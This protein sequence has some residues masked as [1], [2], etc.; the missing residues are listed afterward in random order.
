MD[1]GSPCSAPLTP[2][3]GVVVNTMVVLLLFASLCDVVPSVHSGV[4][5]CPR[6]RLVAFESAS[7][8]RDH[9]RENWP[10][11]TI[12]MSSGYL[13]DIGEDRLIHSAVP[14]GCPEPQ[15]DLRRRSL[16]TIFTAPWRRSRIRSAGCGLLTLSA[17]EEVVTTLAQSAGASSAEEP[18]MLSSS[19]GDNHG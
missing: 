14:E 12:V 6:P 17:A 9:P 19:P 4:P 2:A 13:K 10:P 3:I 16:P 5:Q 8:P 7:E 11:S 15:L 18:Q 1:V